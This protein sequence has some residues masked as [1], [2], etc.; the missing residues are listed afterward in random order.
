[1]RHV[2]RDDGFDEPRI[3]KAPAP[4]VPVLSLIFQNVIP[5]LK[6]RAFSSDPSR[7][8]S[9]NRVTD[10]DFEGATF[11]SFNRVLDTVAFD[12]SRPIIN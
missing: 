2:I 8:R 3:V 11:N 5:D 1:M 12:L 4:I 6:V 7:P 9:V 10:S